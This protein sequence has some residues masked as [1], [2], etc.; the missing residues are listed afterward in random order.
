MTDTHPAQARQAIQAGNILWGAAR[1]ALDRT[2]YER[3]LAPG[4]HV[5]LRG[6]RLARDE[7][8]ERVARDPPDLRLSRFE[9]TV[10]TVQPS[11][12]DWVA[13]I[14]EKLEYR[15]A[16]TGTTDYILAITRDGWR[17]SVSGW[18]ILFSEL[19]GEERWRDGEHPPMGDW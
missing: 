2:L 5:L 17:Q 1:V 9:A 18:Q 15:R 6:Q 8:I 14:L 3:M 12:A 16:S 13:M 19:V 11:G 7:F 10:L 4:F